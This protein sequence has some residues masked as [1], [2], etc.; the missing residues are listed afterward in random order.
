MNA[1]TFAFQAAPPPERLAELCR[2]LKRAGWRVEVR[3]DSLGIDVA[4]R[5]G[6]PLKVAAIATL[7]HLHADVE[8]W[9]KRT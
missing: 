6:R 2:T 8:K 3:P 9:G 4:E 5:Y 7:V 1:L